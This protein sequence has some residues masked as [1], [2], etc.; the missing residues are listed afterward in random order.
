MSQSLCRESLVKA[1]DILP[2]APM[3]ALR[4][5]ANLV[6]SNKVRSGYQSD[7]VYIAINNMNLFALVLALHI[8]VK[9]CYIHKTNEFHCIYTFRL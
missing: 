7:R 4:L 9:K 1:I 3:L 8:L 6:G 5:D 2:Q